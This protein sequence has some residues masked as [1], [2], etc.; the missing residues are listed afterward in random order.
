MSQ[1]TRNCVIC[2]NILVGN[3]KKYCKAECR[4][5]AGRAAWLLKVYGITLEQYDEILR[6]QDGKCA[7]CGTVPKGGK[8]LHVDH[9]HGG[10]VRGLLCGYC[11]TRLVGRLKD[12]AK[13]QRLADYL[14]DP[15]AK[16]IVGDAIA[17]G[18]PKRTRQPRKRQRG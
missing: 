8:P 10:A 5:L 16:A 15:P 13:A 7:I 2:D 4:K 17:P 11:N 6:I 12:H 14:R 18:R 3:Q 1:P 9:E